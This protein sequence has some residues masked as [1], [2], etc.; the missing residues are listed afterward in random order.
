VKLVVI[1]LPR[2]RIWR[3]TFAITILLSE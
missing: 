2:M 1:S 3:I